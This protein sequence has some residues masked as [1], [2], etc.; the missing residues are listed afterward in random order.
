MS[1][2]SSAHS[3]RSVGQLTCLQPSLVPADTHL[4]KMAFPK[5][6]T[7]TSNPVVQRVAGGDMA[8]ASSQMGGYA[9]GGM[10]IHP[11]QPQH[12]HLVNSVL[13]PQVPQPQFAKSL[14]P[15]AV[16][17]P[18]DHTYANFESIQSQPIYTQ[19]AL[20]ATGVF[21]AEAQQTHSHYQQSTHAS[22]QDL[23]GAVTYEVRSNLMYQDSSPQMGF[24][25]LE[26]SYHP[27]LQMS[28]FTD[29]DMGYRQDTSM[30]SGSRPPP[31]S[32]ARDFIVN[33]PNRSYSQ[34]TPP[35]STYALKHCRS[36]GNSENI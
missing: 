11:Q 8:P 2:T 12:Q 18:K 16:S 31:V 29:V 20:H 36:M 26:R 6:M 15:N 3:Q 32:R 4:Q 10:S 28:P 14:M 9:M 35:V 27:D 7:V 17:S 30:V 25:D 34:V 5:K 23:T 24:S 13:L 33:R 19:P 22:Y 21:P 1:R